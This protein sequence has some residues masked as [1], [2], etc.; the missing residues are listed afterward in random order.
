LYIQPEEWCLSPQLPHNRDNTE[1]LMLL[2]LIIVC[3]GLT[4]GTTYTLSSEASSTLVFRDYSPAYRLLGQLPNGLRA[5]AVVVFSSR[6]WRLRVG[7]FAI[8]HNER[9]ISVK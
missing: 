4:L 7:S 9:F 8:V 5:P 1:V 2:V 3:Y 6:K